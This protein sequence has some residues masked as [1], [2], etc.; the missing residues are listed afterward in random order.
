MRRAES[1]EGG[2]TME[3]ENEGRR[4]E[5]GEDREQRNKTSNR[6]NLAEIDYKEN[7]R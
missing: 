5:E 4:K 7:K 2:P 3:V 6:D 1:D